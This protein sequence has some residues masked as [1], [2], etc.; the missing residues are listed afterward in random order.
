M[1]FSRKSGACRRGRS[2]IGHAGGDD[3]RRQRAVKAAIMPAVGTNR[4]EN[5]VC[6]ISICRLSFIDNIRESSLMTR[7]ESP[8]LPVAYVM[9]RILILLNWIGGAAVL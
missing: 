5:F 1:A 6:R 4:T 2:R 7:K 3:E 8:A 9:L